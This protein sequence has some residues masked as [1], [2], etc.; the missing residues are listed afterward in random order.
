MTLGVFFFFCTYL[1]HSPKI[2]SRFS[3]CLLGAV[4]RD[5]LLAVPLANLGP[6]GDG[7]GMDCCVCFGGYGSAVSQQCEGINHLISINRAIT[8]LIK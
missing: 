1:L 6:S 7:E 8:I 5:P 3:R 2:R 4:D